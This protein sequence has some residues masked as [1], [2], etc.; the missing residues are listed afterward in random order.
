MTLPVKLKHVFESSTK[1]CLA[2]LYNLSILIIN[3]S[4]VLA[5][6]GE[7]IMKTFSTVQS[8]IQHSEQ[9]DT[10]AFVEYSDA[11]IA[12]LKSIADGG[13][14][15]KHSSTGQTEYEFW[16]DAEDSDGSDGKMQWRVHCIKD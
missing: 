7:T 12:K 14:T 2:K 10:I 9:F 4:A 5:V 15:T 13:Q 1:I 6:T 11:A 16:G 8:A 3:G